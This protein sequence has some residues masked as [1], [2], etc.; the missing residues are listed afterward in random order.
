MNCDCG[1][2]ARITYRG[3]SYCWECFDI[4]RRL[5]TGV[6]QVSG[7]PNIPKSILDDP[8]WD[9][10]WPSDGFQLPEGDRHARRRA[11]RR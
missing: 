4:A 8:H 3:K 2:P 11:G 10:T 9:G 1:K 6:S 7:V 5:P